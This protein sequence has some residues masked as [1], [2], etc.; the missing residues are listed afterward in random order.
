MQYI[1]VIV[2]AEAKDELSGVKGIYFYKDVYSQ[3]RTS[4]KALTYDGLENLYKENMFKPYNGEIV[5]PENEK[6]VVY[7]RFVDGAGNVVYRTSDGMIID[8]FR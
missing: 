8:S 6:A 1:Y 4:N 3:E 7:V 5:V 2:T